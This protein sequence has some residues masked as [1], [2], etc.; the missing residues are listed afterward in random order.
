MANKNTDLIKAV[1][2]YDGSNAKGNF[3]IQLKAKF[4][5]SELANSLQFV[6]GIGKIICL[7]AIVEGEKVKL[8]KF[9][10]YSIKIDRD[11]NCSIT[12]KS[13][14]YSVFFEDFSKLMIDEATV[15]FVAKVEE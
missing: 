10:I 2:Y 8:G 15:E 3:D 7:V 9:N 4:P 1:G 14:K 11:G 5:E 6:T 13:N 12:F